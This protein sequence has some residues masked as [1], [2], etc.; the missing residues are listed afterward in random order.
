V[1][2]IKSRDLRAKRGG[3]G[4]ALQGADSTAAE[5]LPLEET[6]TADAVVPKMLGKPANPENAAAL[7]AFEEGANGEEE[8]GARLPNRPTPRP[9]VEEEENAVAPKTAVE[10]EAAEMDCA[11]DSEPA[12][13]LFDA[14]TLAAVAG[15]EPTTSTLMTTQTF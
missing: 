12:M 10:E 11:A 6:A 7:E 8:A 4:A 14:K 3:S 5:L 13:P 2:V 1:L 15:G 9:G